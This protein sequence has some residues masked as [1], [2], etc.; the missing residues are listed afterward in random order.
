MPRIPSRLL[1]LLALVLVAM[2]LGAVAR[3]QYFCRVMGRVTTGCCCAQA[4]AKAR[5][6]ARSDDGAC[7]QRQDCCARI[8]ESRG[9][10]PALRDA[11]L[12]MPVA[13]DAMA[14]AVFFVP[15]PAPMGLLLADAVQARAPPPTGPPLYLKNCALLS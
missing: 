15:E 12:R 2:P 6:L 8:Q 10:A 3:E 14:T 5:V 7:I 1:A 11:A 9:A 13:V 4:A